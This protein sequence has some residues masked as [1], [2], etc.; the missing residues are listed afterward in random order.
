[1][2]VDFKTDRQGTARY[3]CQLQW[4]LYALQ[5]LTGRETVGHLLHI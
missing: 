1:V 4:Y 3:E 2:V 5:K